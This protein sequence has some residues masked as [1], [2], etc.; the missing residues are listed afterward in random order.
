MHLTT[1]ISILLAAAVPFSFAAPV[2]A[3]RIQS[4]STAISPGAASNAIVNGFAGLS[5]EEQGKVA[6]APFRALFIVKFEKRAIPGQLL[7][8]MEEWKADDKTEEVVGSVVPAESVDQSN[9]EKRDDTPELGKSSFRL[10]QAKSSCGQKVVELVMVGKP[11]KKRKENLHL[12]SLWAG[13][14]DIS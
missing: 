13:V 11:K 5:D 10:E 1:A 4:S 6:W 8:D 12:G 14:L 2:P 9:K 3:D 7:S